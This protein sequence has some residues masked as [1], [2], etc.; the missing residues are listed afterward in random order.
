MLLLIVNAIS[1]IEVTNLTY[2][3]PR[4]RALD[5]VS[6][7]I[8]TNS[9]TALV[10]PNGAGKTTLL[11]CL[12]TLERPYH[13]NISIAGV[14]VIENPRAVNHLIGFMPDFFGLYDNLTVLQAMTYFSLAYQIEE[15]KIRGNID[16]ILEV[17][18]L[19]DKIHEKVG[20]LSRG[21]RQR[22]AIGQSMVHG[23]KLLMLDEPAS[24]LDP[25]ARSS[26]SKLF[27]SLRDLGMTIIVSSHIL[28]EL[29]EYADQMIVLNNGKVTLNDGI[30]TSSSP[31]RNLEIRIVGPLADLSTKLR[32]LDTVLS[33]NEQAE[34]VTFAFTGDKDDQSMLLKQ[35]IADGFRVSEFTER[36]SKLQ[37]QYLD[38]VKK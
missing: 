6:F 1:M 14:D 12:A 3:Y 24:G 32:T 37:D 21:M 16:H 5:D 25:E 38:I 15:D 26:L 9:I 7:K 29:D 27:L 31:T 2:E 34:S 30:D 35:L 28:S 13:G 23:P 19:S 8:E 10:G 4:H 33:V 18:N 17:L 36:R 22:L 20:A 11:K